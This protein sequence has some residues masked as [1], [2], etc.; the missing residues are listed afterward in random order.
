MYRGDGLNRKEKKMNRKMDDSG[1]E[2]NREQR[3][4]QRRG[5]TGAEMEK[6]IYP[7]EKKPEFIYLALK[8][9]TN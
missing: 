5:K 9:K 3:L 8:K 1:L 7:R 2:G 6:G 4:K